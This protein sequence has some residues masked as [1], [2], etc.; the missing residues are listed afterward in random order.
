MRLFLCAALSAAV[1]LAAAGC[2]SDDPASTSATTA[3]APGATTA[4][5]TTSKTTTTAVDPATARKAFLKKVN[6]VCEDYN[7]EVQDVQKDLQSVGKTGNVDVYAPALKRATKAAERASKRF[8]AVDPPAGDEAQAALIG[9]ALKAQATGN[10][11]LLEAAEADDPQQFGIA[12]EALQQIT[13]K[14]QELMRQYGMTVCGAA[15]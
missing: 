13:P 4:A 9:R 15:A 12:T 11:L 1:L 3:V 8:D 10:K 5:T 14:L 6:P 7:E 2:G